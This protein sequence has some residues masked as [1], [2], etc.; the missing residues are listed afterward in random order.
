M[1]LLHFGASPNPGPFLTMREAAAAIAAAIAAVRC[2][3][4]VVNMGWLKVCSQH[5]IST[6][7]ALSE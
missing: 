6:K 5:G 2:S 4:P 3:V 1:V 7:N